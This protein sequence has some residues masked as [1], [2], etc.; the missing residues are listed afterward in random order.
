MCWK[1][2][3]KIEQLLN[4]DIPLFI[5]K[6]RQVYAMISGDFTVERTTAIIFSVRV[7][8][9]LWSWPSRRGHIYII[10]ENVVKGY[11]KG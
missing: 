4:V 1:H 7:E 8:F 11:K 5:F 2:A 6:S 9:E 10:S 3:L